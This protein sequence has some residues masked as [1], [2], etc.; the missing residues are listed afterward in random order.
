MSSTS[1]TPC[2]LYST[3]SQALSVPLYTRTKKYVFKNAKLSKNKCQFSLKNLD[4]K[5]KYFSRRLDFCT[6]SIDGSFIVLWTSTGLDYLWLKN[7]GFNSEP[8]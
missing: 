4:R 5:K 6:V 1:H 2:S 3:L 7:S 8:G